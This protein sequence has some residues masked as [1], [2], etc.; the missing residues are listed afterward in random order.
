MNDL[1]WY[2]VQAHPRKE[3]FVRDRILEMDRE[4]FLPLVAERTTPRRTQA[5][6]SLFP[7]YL[8]A[9]LSAGQGDFPRVRWARG[10][11]RLLGHG[12]RPVPVDEKLI[13][14]L[15]NRVDRH[16]RMRMDRVLRGGARVRIVDGP[17]AGLVGVLDRRV[18]SPEDRVHVLLD[19]FHRLTR[20]ELEAR[21]LRG[22]ATA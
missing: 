18:A 10:V 3:R 21:A 8:F 19:L 15:R 11:R 5:S 9:R 13:K 7:G 12:D 22:E 6:A 17:F 4:A 14:I 2:V 20:V 16:G 1:G